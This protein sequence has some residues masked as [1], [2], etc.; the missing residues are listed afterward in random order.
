[1]S[2][3][4]NFHTQTYRRWDSGSERGAWNS[5]AG[6]HERVSADSDQG[7]LNNPR[8]LEL[9]PDPQGDLFNDLADSTDT[10]RRR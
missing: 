8:Q 7:A 4:G 3:A 1:M 10:G 6:R 2:G 5:A 9:L